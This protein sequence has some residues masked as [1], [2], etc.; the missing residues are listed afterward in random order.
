MHE[1]A[2]AGLGIVSPGLTSCESRLLPGIALAC[3]RSSV[4]NLDS[5]ETGSDGGTGGLDVLRNGLVLEGVAMVG[6]GPVATGY[7]ELRPGTTVLYGLNGAGKSSVLDSLAA[8]LS[9]RPTEGPGRSL[10]VVRV[11]NEP[12]AAEFIR[13]ALDTARLEQH[14]DLGAGI[15]EAVLSALPP[16]HPLDG[17]VMAEEVAAQ[18]RLLVRPGFEPA[19]EAFFI[20][21]GALIDDS[22]PTLGLLMKLLATLDTALETLDGSTD[23]FVRQALGTFGMEAPTDGA[24][25]WDDASKLVVTFPIQP[26]FGWSS[27]FD[28]SC[29]LPALV[30]ID[31]W[32]AN[33]RR[34]LPELVLESV[35]AEE[36]NQQLR[37]LLATPYTGPPADIPPPVVDADTVEPSIVA[38]CQALGAAATEELQGIL[39]TELQLRAHIR[40]PREWL[41]HPP[42]EWMGVKP[43]GELVRLSALSRAEQRWAKVAIASA[44][45]PEDPAI[46]AM[47]LLHPQPPRVRI[48][49]E[50]EAALHRTAEAR[51]ARRLLASDPARWVTVVATHSPELL[52]SAANVVLLQ[53][54][55][56]GRNSL[57]PWSNEQLDDLDSL[58]LRP[59]ELLG[60]YKIMLAVEGP[61]DRWILEELLRDDFERLRVVVVPMYGGKQ[62]PGLGTAGVLHEFTDWVM[63]PLW[64]NLRSN[65]LSR[66]WAE[67]KASAAAGGTVEDLRKVAASAISGSSEASFARQFMLLTAMSRQ[68]HRCAEP[69]GMSEPDVLHYL[70]PRALSAKLPASWSEVQAA[71]AA[72]GDKDEKKFLKTRFNLT[73][74]EDEVRGAARSMDHRPS[75]F[76]A[77]VAHLEGVL[78]TTRSGAEGG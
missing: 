35:S 18:K 47:G 22:T 20:S 55:P 53:P 52:D 33:A 54:A 19:G 51:M 4:G 71:Q 70:P 61:H 30:E 40:A 5:R 59:S 42:A 62:T 50:P 3:H 6:R 66:A 11:S 39:D 36:L 13:D 38:E 21:V 44:N 63:V 14:E 57:L 74:D 69:F 60:R 24:D 45:L 76:T 67:M 58:G 8:V 29:R 32:G 48:F 37:D 23:E 75:D 1:V 15:E 65:E 28:V 2:A 77:L 10:L 64:D 41:A 7:L 16:G 27:L 17:Y 46:A 9:G 73:L 68:W 34:F 43:T 25:L 56:A 12:L 78:N 31:L 49:D 72:A 26:V